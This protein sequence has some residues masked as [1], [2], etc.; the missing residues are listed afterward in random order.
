ML[1]A[2]HAGDLRGKG[3]IKGQ[4]RQVEPH[5]QSVESLRRHFQRLDA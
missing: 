1:H 3:F 4:G 5:R 2:M